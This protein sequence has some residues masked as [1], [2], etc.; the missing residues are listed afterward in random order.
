MAGKR[1]L[2]L[3]ALKGIG[4]ILVIISHSG[5]NIPYLNY[6][7]AG[8]IQ[9]FFVVAGFTYKPNLSIVTSLRKKASRLMIPYFFYGLCTLLLFCMIG[10]ANLKNGLEGLLY[11][12]HSLQAFPNN[13]DDLLLPKGTSP[14]WFLPAMFTAY[15]LVCVV[16]KSENNKVISI[17]IILLQ[18][19]LA[20]QPYLFPW[21][22]DIS[23]FFTLCILF[24]ALCKNFFFTNK[25]LALF[26]VALFSYVLLIKTNGNVNLSIREFGN[27]GCLSLLLCFLIGIVYTFLLSFICRAFEVSV[28]VKYLGIIGK[29]SLRLMCIHYPIM[30]FVSDLLWH[31]HVKHIEGSV[32]FGIQIVTIAVCALLIQQLVVKCS[33]RFSLLKYL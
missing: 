3:D 8:Y 14:L 28:I 27:F 11:G 18:V 17:V 21:S 19:G 22:L 31:L 15:I 12:C 25:S 10:G 13:G 24:G 2:W 6:L 30:I 20:L 32:L 1:I 29:Q 9:L 5:L 16:E 33:S 26:M 4:I 7:T 23:V